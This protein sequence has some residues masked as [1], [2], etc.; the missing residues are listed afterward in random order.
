MNS[1]A[2]KFNREIIKFLRSI[3]DK[4]SFYMRKKTGHPV[5][6]ATYGGVKKVLSLS[7]TPNRSYQRNMRSRMNQF[8]RS[9][10][11]KPQSTFTF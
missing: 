8:I 9:L 10:P 3:A 4:G 2:L 6:V 11:I 7:N 5:C 1:E